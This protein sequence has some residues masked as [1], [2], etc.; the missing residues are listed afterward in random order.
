MKVRQLGKKLM[1]LGWRAGNRLV[2]LLAGCV[3]FY[4]LYLAG[5]STSVMNAAEH[6]WL[7]RDSFVCNMLFVI[8]VLALFCLLRSKAEWLRRFE[9]RINEDDEFYGRCRRNVLVLLGIVC[10]AVLLILQKIPVNDQRTVCDIVNSMMNHDF[11]AFERG[12]Y[13]DEYPNQLGLVLILYL[14][15]HVFG[16]YNYLLFQLLNVIA[17]IVIYQT[18]TVLAEREGDSH[19]AQLGL[20]V[21]GLIFLPAVLY[22]AFVYG[23]LIGLCLSLLAFRHTLELADAWGMG[24]TSA[25]GGR[26][27]CRRYELLRQWGKLAQIILEAFL[28]VA[29]KQNYMINV[30]AL[31]IVVILLVMKSSSDRC[32]GM[33]R[34]GQEPWLS[35]FCM[36]VQLFLLV[37]A[38][39]GILLFS[40]RAITKCAEKATGMDLGS[41]ISSL[42]WVAMGL[43]ENPGRFNG[44][45]NG[46]N[47]NSY[48]DANSS[49]ERQ[50]PVVKEYLKERLT[51]FREDPAGALSFFA[52]KN[53]SQWNNPDFQSSWC[54]NSMRSAVVYP[55]WI[56]SLL[57]ATGTGM[58]SSV[59][60]RLQFFILFGCA[61]YFLQGIRNRS[62]GW[63]PS[64]MYYLLTFLGGFVF[65][66]FWE[67]KAQYTF[68]YFM[69]LIPIAVCGYAHVLK[70][71]G[72]YDCAAGG[73]P[74]V[75]RLA[76]L[77][78]WKNCELGV[79]ILIVLAGGGIIFAGSR[80]LGWMRS[81]FVQT[82]CEEGT[83]AYRNYQNEHRY[84]RLSEG[85]Y[86]LE[87]ADAADE[88][89]WEP[90]SVRV[91]LSEYGDD[92]WLVTEEGETLTAE[93]SVIRYSSDSSFPAVLSGMVH[94]S[95]QSVYVRR[96]EIDDVYYLIHVVDAKELAVT[97]DPEG[98]GG[99]SLSA[100][101]GEENQR[102]RIVRK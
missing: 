96:T 62:A 26:K 48:H 7:V 60:N 76:D 9:I 79:V 32:E 69:L 58:V 68:P 30:V 81:L 14:F 44:W 73:R 74:I 12:G 71:H 17:L 52:G 36:G 80:N 10:A 22:T 94:S 33:A 38:L 50:D 75:S 56:R 16:S 27:S 102:W 53:A 24:P 15:A 35:R 3:I 13:I 31:L 19:L 21:I 59:L 39:A 49:K 47:V 90:T 8:L 41:G 78:D 43:Q 82:E 100:C 67:A 11:Y 29:L 18:M 28:A 51:E 1:N 63:E 99:L 92:C 57:S 34:D 101:T 54:V 98:A 89:G 61:A 66:T 64:T 23:T 84:V 87:A 42:S 91:I 2:L 40:G 72:T 70:E 4:L 25:N 83:A 55:R 93:D 65:H 20:W 5:F 86:V 95:E 97:R 77:K 6:T 88:S 37:A 46:Y 45:Y 85:P